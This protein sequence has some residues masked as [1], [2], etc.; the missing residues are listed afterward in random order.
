MPTHPQYAPTLSRLQ[1]INPSAEVLAKVSAMIRDPHNEIEDIALVLR[2]DSSLTTD[3]IRMSNS[4]YYG[5]N[6]PATHLDEALKRIGLREAQRLVNMSLAKSVFSKSLKHYQLAAWHVWASGVACAT[7][8]ELIAKHAQLQCHEGHTLGTL[9]GLGK[10]VIDTLMNVGNLNTVWDKTVPVEV[11]EV[12]HTGVN[13]AQAGADLLKRWNFP[14][15]MVKAIAEHLAPSENASP[16]TCALHLAVNILQQTGCELK[17]DCPTFPEA[18]MHRLQIDSDVL[19][20]LIEE[21]RSQFIQIAETLGMK[22]A[23]R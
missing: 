4:P 14:D 21:G 5:Q 3:L 19:P 7:L 9:H 10:Q 12:E 17:G 8:M 11:W 15:D 1:R 13:Y 2:T 20:E 23:S 22:Q 6:T 18:I 16:V